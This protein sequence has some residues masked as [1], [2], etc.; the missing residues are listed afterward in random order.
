[1][2]ITV[3][4]PRYPSYTAPPHVQREIDDLIRHGEFASLQEFITAALEWYLAQRKQLRAAGRPTSADGLPDSAPIEITGA[5]P[6]EASERAIFNHLLHTARDGGRLTEPDPEWQLMLAELLPL[7]R[8]QS[9]DSVLESLSGQQ[10][11]M[12][13]HPAG[14]H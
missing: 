5:H 2:T 10:C 14:V 6:P 11:S 7:A 13:N 1:M 8:H 3:T 12:Q 4:F 9:K